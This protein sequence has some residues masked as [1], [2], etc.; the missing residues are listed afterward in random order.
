MD[1]DEDVPAK[2]V[3]KTGGKGSS[4]SCIVESPGEP[5][6]DPPLTNYG[7]DITTGVYNGQIDS[8]MPKRC[9]N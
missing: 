6:V 1:L 9:F 8:G 7:D 3:P 5:T 4:R 2:G